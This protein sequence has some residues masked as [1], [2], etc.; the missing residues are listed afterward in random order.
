MKT[1]LLIIIHILSSVRYKN[2]FEIKL[3][4]IKFPHFFLK[5]DF[6]TKIELKKYIELMHKKLKLRN[7]RLKVLR[8][9][10]IF[11]LNNIL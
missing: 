6:R 7:Y 8:Y 11:S 2:D 4:E 3:R 9:F 10:F 5:K 1:F